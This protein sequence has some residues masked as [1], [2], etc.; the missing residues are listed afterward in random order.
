MW[1]NNCLCFSGRPVD[2]WESPVGLGLLLWHTA[3]EVSLSNLWF[4]HTHT[5]YCLVAHLWPLRKEAS[6]ERIPSWKSKVSHYC[7]NN[8]HKPLVFCGH[9][10]EPQWCLWSS[11]RVK[12]TAV[13][14]WCFFGA[15]CRSRRNNFT[16]KN[17]SVYIFLV[18][19]GR[20]W[21]GKGAWR[22]QRGPALIDVQFSGHI[23]RARGQANSN[24]CSPPSNLCL[25]KS[26][27]HG[28]P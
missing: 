6:H 12:N 17:S 22:R 18:S 2:H 13:T 10:P 5:A 25:G 20:M 26:E 4:L 9:P 28:S 3:V 7:G 21:G 27:T 1:L 24:R 8:K 16:Y 11:K 15:V 23:R 19:S 14:A